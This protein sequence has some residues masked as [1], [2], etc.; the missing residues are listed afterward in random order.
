MTDHSI[1]IVPKQSSY[2]DNQVKA[3]EILNW[4]LAKN[5]VKPTLLACI[6]GANK[7]YAMAD[8]AKQITVHLNN[9][10]FDL[11]TNG[12]EIITERSVFDTGENFIDE[13]TCPNCKENIV[14]NDWD[15]TP[16]NNKE[17]DNLTC[18]QC[19][20]ETEIHNYTFVPNWGFSNLGFKF[21]NWPDFTN[22]FIDEFKQKLNCEI[23]IVNQH[24]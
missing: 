12:L 23:S 15:L 19:Q 13:L 14:A 10:P 3:R 24:I 16:W 4:L 8:G 5:I 20:Q 7:G 9:L 2:T 1:S 6:L 18:P 17:T 21:W 22:D 11:I